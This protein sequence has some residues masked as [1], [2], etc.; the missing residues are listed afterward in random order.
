VR[1]DPGEHDPPGAEVDEEHHVGVLSRIVSTVN[2]SHA[3]IPSACA[4][5]NCVQVGPSVAAP[6]R[7]R[8][9]AAAS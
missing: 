6:G 7:G 4:L 3:T 5:R 2:K 8:V 9:V 1:R